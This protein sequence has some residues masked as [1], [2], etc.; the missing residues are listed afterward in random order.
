MTRR[1]ALIS[2][3]VVG[4]LVLARGFYAV[5]FWDWNDRQAVL[6]AEVDALGWP[7]EAHHVRAGGYANAGLLG[8]RTHAAWEVDG[9]RY[10]LEL[11]QSAPLF[12]WRVE[13]AAVL[14]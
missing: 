10:E 13:R 3:A 7:V 12:P 8:M 14:D 11:A 1:T 5:T 9:T 4:G 2:L 6:A